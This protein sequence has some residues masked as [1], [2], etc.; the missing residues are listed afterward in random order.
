MKSTWQT[1]VLGL[2]CAVIASYHTAA[3]ANLPSG[4]T[5]VM[6]TWLFGFHA[7]PASAT[8]TERDETFRYPIGD[9]QWT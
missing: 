8:T 2:V 5:P 9:T 7:V 3:N 6:A 1:V 4:I